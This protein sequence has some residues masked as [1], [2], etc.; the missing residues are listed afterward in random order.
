[1]GHPASVQAKPVVISGF[2]VLSPIGIGADRFEEGMSSGR[3]GKRVVTNL[4]STAVTPSEVG[5]IEEFHAASFLGTKGTRF[6]DR[7]TSL[8]VAACGMALQS[9]GLTITDEN[10]GRV[11]VAVGTSTGSIKSMC[12]FIQDTLVQERPY[13]VNPVLFPNTVINCAAGQAAIWHGLK[14]VNATLSGGELSG[15][16]SLRYA[17]MTLRQ[18]YADSILVGSVEELC[19]QTVHGVHAAGLLCENEFM[20]EGCAMFLLEPTDEARRHGRQPMAEVLAC[21]VSLCDEPLPG[22]DFR[23]QFAACI[24]RALDRAGVTPREVTTVFS[25]IAASGRLAATELEAVGMAIGDSPV[26]V[27]RITELVGDC[28]SANGSMQLAACLT[29]FRSQPGGTGRRVGLIS[30]VSHTGYAGC[31]VIGEVRS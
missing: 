27:V 22:S 19:P 24:K 20:G 11:G 16:M 4:F 21:E 30:S 17:C 5:F 29:T 1:M 14:G 9:G 31:A 23:H 25:G 2:G 8:V 10:R 26:N 28:Y 12:D 13:L 18:G 3:A 15:L 6:F 7:T